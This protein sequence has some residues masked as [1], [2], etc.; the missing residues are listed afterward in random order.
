MMLESLVTPTN[1]YQMI[2]LDR[3]KFRSIDGR[4][5]NRTSL[6][7]NIGRFSKREVGTRNYVAC[8]DILKK[9]LTQLI[10]RL[11]DILTPCHRNRY[12]PHW[13]GSVMMGVVPTIQPLPVHQIWAVN[14]PFRHITGQQYRVHAVDRN[15]RTS[16][17]AMFIRMRTEP[18]EAFI[19]HRTPSNQLP[20][21]L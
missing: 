6:F 20:A 14:D 18:R 10:E 15:S 4:P 7:A 2:H 13:K 19:L 1:D 9:Q 17:I 12:F 21:S 5:V 8:L 11:L 16:E 3:G